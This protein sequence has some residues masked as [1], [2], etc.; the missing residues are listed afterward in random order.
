M[1]AVL[2]LRCGGCG[3][4]LQ[5]ETWLSA[6]RRRRGWPSPRPPV[7][8]TSFTPTQAQPLL[9]A[10]ASLAAAVTVRDMD[11]TAPLGVRRGIQTQIEV[12]PSSSLFGQLTAWAALP[13]SA[14]ISRCSWQVVLL[15]LY[16]GC[17]WHVDRGGGE[18][19]A[20]TMV[21]FR[22]SR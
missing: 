12:R 9:A 6:G 11:P 17:S 5:A 2:S 19:C 8:S 7:L 22:C 1:L 21:A 16:V 20:R 18:A 10:A 13:G 15:L 3:W 4:H 14:W